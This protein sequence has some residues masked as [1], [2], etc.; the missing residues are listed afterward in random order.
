[1]NNQPLDDPASSI[2][3]TSEEAQSLLI[4]LTACKIAISNLTINGDLIGQENYEK[5]RAWCDRLEGQS[6]DNLI[7]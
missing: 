5:L 7:T 3:L 1:M 4:V 6:L 2:C